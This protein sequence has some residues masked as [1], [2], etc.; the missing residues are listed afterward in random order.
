MSVWNNTAYIAPMNKPV[1][2]SGASSNGTSAARS[3][4]FQGCYTDAQPRTL[5]GYL[6]SRNDTTQEICASTYDGMGY[7]FAGVEYGS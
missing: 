3:F 4:S 5:S 6:T 2:T 1:I 7:K